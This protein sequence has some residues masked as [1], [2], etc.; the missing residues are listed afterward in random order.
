V[1]VFTVYVKVV[2]AFAGTLIA[3]LTFRKGR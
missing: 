2:L 3:R 1:K